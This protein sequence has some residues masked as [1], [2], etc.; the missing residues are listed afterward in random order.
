[1]TEQ[2]H[3]DR[4]INHMPYDA[5]ET[6]K[7]KWANVKGDGREMWRVWQTVYNE[8]KQGKLAEK[9]G[10]FSYENKDLGIE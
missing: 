10:K 1:M 7:N 3:Q 2:V 8:W 6:L 9:K 4:F 5:R